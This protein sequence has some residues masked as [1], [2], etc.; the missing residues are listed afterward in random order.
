MNGDTKLSVALASNPAVLDYV[1]S[2]NPHDFER[3]RNPLMRKVMPVRITLRRIANMAGIPEQELLDNIN[4]L[5][6]EPLEVVD[7]DRAPVKVSASQAPVWMQGVDDSQIVWVDVLEGDERLDDPMP[8]INTAVN[9]MKSGGVIGIKH[10]W[11]PQPLFDIWD[12]RGLDYWTKQ[13]STDEW[14]IYVHKP[15]EH[16][17]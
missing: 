17:V 5:A 9:T 3:L 11:E 7:P 1:I 8:P 12:L 10:K 2:L 13:I 15:H 16:S 14:H 6:G 4:R